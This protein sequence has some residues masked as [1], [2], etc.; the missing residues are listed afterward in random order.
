MGRKRARKKFSCDFETTTLE[1]DC[2]VWGY[3]VMEINN[4]GNYH[5]GNNIDDFMNW[6]EKGNHDLYFHNLRFDGSFIVNWLLK[7]GY[8]YSDSGL[9]KTFD[10]IISN[11]GQWYAI[12]IC[13][14][15]RGKTKLHTKIFDSLKKLPFSVEVIGK[16]FN[17]ATLKIDVNEAWYKRFR[18]VGHKITDEEYEYIK[19]DIKVVAEALEIQFKQGLDA[20]T[21]GSDSLKGYKN[22]ISRKTYDKLFPTFSLGLDSELRLAY[23]GGFTWV[24]EKF[25]GKD[26]GAGIVFD[27][28]SLY[29]SVMYN[30]LLPYGKPISYTGEYK[31]DDD[32]PLYIQHIRCEF[33]IKKD[34]IP[35]IQIKHKNQRINF[36][37]NEYLKSSKGEVVDLYVTNVDL[38]LMLEH[39]ELY[40]LEYLEG[41]KF[42]GR[43][44]MFNK[45]IDRWSFVKNTEKGA[46][47]ELAKL[48]LN[49][50]YGKFATNPDVTGKV[51]YLREDGSLGFYLGDQEYK[52]PEYTPM[53]VF[54]TSYAREITISTAQSVFDR[55]IYCD[56]DSIHLVG[57]EIPEQLKGI[58]DPLEMGKW[59]HEATFEKAR[60]L[61]QKTY[62][63]IIDGKL[64][65][66]CAGM[67]DRVKEKVT[68]ENFQLGFSAS[69]NL[70]GKQVSGGIVLNDSDFSLK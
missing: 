24:N 53:G 66:T 29:P 15:Y 11:M 38:E 23:R 33:V 6:C 36:K 34:R 48:M 5:I 41:W 69:G 40:D 18:P 14:G 55:I 46:L 52:D 56:T 12:D 58:I 67:S 39:Y 47:R 65:V 16:A 1:D 61:K 22:I 28:N 45:Y 51:P 54:I 3:G 35:T 30:D 62:V 57:T 43:S 70:K 19:H 64:S 68:W 2:R 50:L 8:E 25:Q 17:L 49:N 44:G 26:L 27:V 4:H 13:Y 9:P 7:N 59:D 10:A 32:Y 60:Y 21:I 37:K 31:K 20:M 63:Y 42:Q